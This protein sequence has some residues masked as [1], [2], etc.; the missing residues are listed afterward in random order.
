[1]R[2]LGADG[3]GRMRWHLVLAAGMALLPLASCEAL[4]I[5][6]GRED[7]EATEAGQST[8]SI[9]SAL[10]TEIAPFLLLIPTTQPPASPAT[11]PLREEPEHDYWSVLEG[12]IY[13]TGDSLWRID[14]GGPSLLASDP[15][16]VSGQVAQT[17]GGIAVLYVEDRDIRTRYL[18]TGMDVNLTQTPEIEEREPQWCPE[19]PDRILF[20]RVPHP[21]TPAAS[22]TLGMVG[23]DGTGYE[24]LG[25]LDE[26]IWFSS[27]PD[28]GAVAYTFA[29]SAWVWRWETGGEVLEPADYGLDEIEGWLLHDPAW[30]PDGALLAWVATAPTME[31]PA[32]NRV[33]LF[34]LESR[35]GQ[36]LEPPGETGPYGWMPGMV[37]SPDG[38]W[39]VYYPG[40]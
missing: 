19:R 15:A 4:S 37:W 8:A 21:G 13:R 20:R 5:E 26:S 28:C 12:L 14:P 23:T 25:E 11:Q 3:E 2:Q 24:V 32:L 6:T 27:S 22:G 16:L 34:D 10:A 30:S 35:A 38:R 1:M 9:A 33:V 7:L 39:L 17:P 36:Y 18:D 31:F 40:D 29:R